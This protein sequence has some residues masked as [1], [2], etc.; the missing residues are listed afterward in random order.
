MPLL[1]V[2]PLLPA[3]HHDLGLNEAGVAALTNI[4]VLL[5]GVAAIPGSFAIARFGARRAAI[6]SLW[7]IAIA[8]LLRGVGTSIF[9]LY[10]MTALMGIGVAMAQP[11]LPTLVREWYPKRIALA[12]SVWANGLLCG[13]AIAA[14][15][16]LPFLVPL[17]GGA[18]QPA[19]DVWGIPVAVTAAAFVLAAPAGLD[20][21]N[22]VQIALPDFRNPR[23]W[24]L[25]VLQSAASLTYFGANTF[26]PDYLHANGRP[27]LVAGC[28]AALNVGQLPASLVVGF[29]PFS[30]LSRR[31]APVLVGATVLAALALF[32]YGGAAGAVTASALFGFSA[33]Y[34]LVFSFALPAL[35][36]PSADVARVA[37]GTFTIG[38]C[39][40]FLTTLGAG[41]AWDATRQPVWA[42]LPAIAAAFIIAGFGIRLSDLAREAGSR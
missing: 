1:A 16:T 32:L 6:A 15:I 23:V 39:I 14:S 19:L 8:A 18:W 40:S 20:A 4:P 42:F 26:I 29:V 12:T 34:V 22:V 30:I 38:Y 41:A 21:A 13:E 27:E 28:L 25:G 3:I 24:Q 33:A 37:S 9:M 2:P 11:A 36:A 35:L 17:F 7:L 31:L 10:A 5:L